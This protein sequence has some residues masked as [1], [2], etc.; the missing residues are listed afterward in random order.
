[1]LITQLSYRSKIHWPAIKRNLDDEVAL[2]LGRIRRINARSGV[3]GALVLTDSHVFQML[4]GPWDAVKITFE[5]ALSDKRHSDLTVLCNEKVQY[6]LFNC[7]WMHFCDLREGALEEYPRF[8]RALATHSEYTSHEEFKE[9]LILLSI[10]LKE[11]AITN[12]LS[13]M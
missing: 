2:T 7:S 6:R 9:V 3:T 10:G 12:H 5:C 13:L 11:N 4:E 1:M 8:I